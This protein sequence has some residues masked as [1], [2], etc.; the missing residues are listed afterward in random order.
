MPCRKRQGIFFCFIIKTKIM[1]KNILLLLLVCNFQTASALSIT[2]LVVSSISGAN[3]VNV[4]VQSTHTNSFTF[5]ESNYTVLGSIITLNV[6]YKDGFSAVISNDYRNVVLSGIN[7][8]ANNYTLIVNLYFTNNVVSNEC[9]YSLIKSTA[10]LNFSTPLTNTVYLENENFENYPNKIG[11]YPNP[12]KGKFTI[13]N[14]ENFNIEIY[15][16]LG[17]L[18]FTKKAAQNVIET[19]LKKGIY[20]VKI[21]SEEG[22]IETQKMVVD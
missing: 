7:L 10:T 18:V 9:N 5:R 11:L 2:N 22:K 8:T 14:L 1:K 20:F 16:I 15:D 17:H 12:N 3:D 19:G 21:T 13:S 4:Q 6:C